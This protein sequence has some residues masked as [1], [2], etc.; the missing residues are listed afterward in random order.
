VTVA[1]AAPAELLI[2]LQPNRVVSGRVEFVG[3][4]P[5]PELTGPQRLSGPPPA[6]LPRAGLGPFSIELRPAVISPGASMMVA[7]VRPDATFSTEGSGPGPF[8][9]R[10]APTGRGGPWTQIA[11]IIDGIDT[12][13]VPYSGR[14]STD[15]VVIFADRVTALF[16]NVRDDNDRPVGDATVILF[17]DDPRYWTALSRRMRLAP[18]LPGG[19]TTLYEM[20][21][22]KYFIAASRDVKPAQEITPAFIESI[23]PRAL[24]L[25]MAVGENR[26]VTVRVR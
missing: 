5:P 14:G 24:P 8:V 11:G 10:G 1:G 9:L 12:L 21:P 20:P 22:G 26:S 4:T 16:V 6:G 15:A 18:V 17:A 13:D 3:Q 2:Q 23:K 7:P 25:E 19:T